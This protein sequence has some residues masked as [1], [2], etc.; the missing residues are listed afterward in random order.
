MAVAESRRSPAPLKAMDGP[1][2]TIDVKFSA[3]VVPALS[4]PALPAGGGDPGKALT[5]FLAAVAKKQ[6]TGIKAGLGPTALAM[7]DKDYN[8]P[9]ENA[10]SR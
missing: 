7:F 8:S 5:A 2:Y 3:D 6:W 10:A 1:S 9:A 4:G